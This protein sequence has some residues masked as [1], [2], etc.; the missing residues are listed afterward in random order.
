MTAR[1]KIRVAIVDDHAVIREG[2]RRILADADGVEVVGEAADGI[3]ALSLIRSQE[4]DL[5]LL[6]ISMPGMNGFDVL[7]AI[8]HETSGIAVLMLS[9]H[10]EDQFA[11]RALKAGA[12][13]YLT[14]DTSRSQI[15]AAI[16]RVSQGRKCVSS[17]VAKRLAQ[18]A[19]SSDAGLPHERLTDL[20]F[21]ILRFVAGGRTVG[22]TAREM[23]LS[24]ETVNT[25]HARLLQKMNMKTNDELAR[26]ALDNGLVN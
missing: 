6:D 11:L 22:E 1:N 7:H 14:K 20:E 5:V 26:Y 24:V 4:C 17:T 8:K 21:E 15:I 9:M 13:G 12:A 18:D 19:N 25:Y 2:L 10:P 23:H 16:R 3:A